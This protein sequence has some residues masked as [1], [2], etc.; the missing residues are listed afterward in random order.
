M[1]YF[2]T[3][4]GIIIN[5]N[6][7][8]IPMQEGNELYNEYLA[9]LQNEGE[10]FETDYLTEED[11]VLQRNE[12]VPFEVPLWSMRTVLKQANLF[13]AIIGA[14]QTLDEPTRSIA[15]DYLEY[16]NY[17][18]RYSNTVGMIQQITGL[19]ETQVD[20]LFINA[21]AIKL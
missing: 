18:E 17:I 12:I 9:Y 7:E 8:V 13:D 10:I 2:R 3:K 4:F 14:I 11:L 6:N 15:L 1:K 16:G 5:E 19:S 21:N 20:D